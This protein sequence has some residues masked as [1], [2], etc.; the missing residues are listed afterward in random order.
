[1]TDLLTNRKKRIGIAVLVLAVLAIVAMCYASASSSLEFSVD[2]G[3]Y[4]EPITLKISGGAMGTIHYTLDG[5]EP[6]VDSEL[7]TGGIELTDATELPNRASAS[8]DSSTGFDTEMIE[9]YGSYECEFKVPDYNVDKIY[10]VRAACFDAMGNKL[11]E[12]DGQYFLNFDEKSIYDDM[13]IVSITTDE[14]NLWDPDIGIY[15]TG[16]TYQQLKEAVLSGEETLDDTTPWKF[17]AANYHNEGMDWERECQVAVYDESHELIMD[18]AA[19]LRMQGHGAAGENQKAFAIFARD[20]YS[21]SNT[22][23]TDLTNSGYNQHRYILTSGGQDQKY[24]INDY[25]VFGSVADMDVSTLDYRPCMMFLNGEFWGMYYISEC[26]NAEYVNGHYGVAK[27]NVI[28]YKNRNVE[29]G[30]EE[31]R[32]LYQEMYDFITTADMTDPANYEK[33][34]EYIDIDSFV[35]YYVIMHYV[36]RQGDWPDSNEAVWRARTVES[37]NEYGDGRW[38]WMLFDLN[39]PELE[40]TNDRVDNY[41]EQVY[42]DMWR[43]MLTNDDFKAKYAER[44][45][46]LANVDF[47]PELMNT[48]IDEYLTNYMDALMASN[49][50]F[51]GQTYEEEILNRIYI[52]LKYYFTRR[53]DITPLIV[54]QFCGDQYNELYGGQ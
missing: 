34:G 39:G 7:Y 28:I 31:D 22:F 20:E 10:L 14:A 35:D 12:I 11:Q 46:Y 2:P 44:F 30:T 19:G 42:S 4:D 27:D 1:M 25:L 54:A 40:L 48:K 53:H 6:T 24:K 47:E 23:P 49:M 15:T 41:D 5:S 37:G 26:F 18:T 21:G 9:A 3:F 38:R 51:Y 32:E 33:A 16:T 45:W 17:W 52:E 36:A 29:E 43:N 8:T 13:A 50:R